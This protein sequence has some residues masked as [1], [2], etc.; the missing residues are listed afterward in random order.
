[1]DWNA[2]DARERVAQDSFKGIETQHARWLYTNLPQGYCDFEDCLSLVRLWALEAVDL[3]DPKRGTKFS[4]WL[5]EHVWLRV[6]QYQPAAWAKKRKPSGKN[7]LCVSQCSK[8]TTTGMLHSAYYFEDE[9]SP[10]KFEELRRALTDRTAEVL[11]VLMNHDDQKTLQR[12]FKSQFCR[13]K[14]S[15]I[16]GVPDEDLRIAVEEIRE[17][18]PV[19]L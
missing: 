5:Y 18:A 8:D 1:M 16:T 15:A 10:L 6:R 2:V 11:E 7:V 12:A 4:S 3:Y 19:Y 14:V 17:K 9:A 13:R